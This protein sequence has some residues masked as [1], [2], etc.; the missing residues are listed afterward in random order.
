[1]LGKFASAQGIGCGV[2]SCGAQQRGGAREGLVPAALWPIARLRR[3]D[4]A[5]RNTAPSPRR[6]H[7]CVRPRRDDTAPRNAAQ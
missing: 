2:R 4:T 5:P 1:M 7:P 6:A 3:D